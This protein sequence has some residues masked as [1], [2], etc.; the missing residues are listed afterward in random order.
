MYHQLFYEADREHIHVTVADVNVTYFFTSPLFL[1]FHLE[2][3]WS[4]K[5]SHV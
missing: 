2:V 3:V 4:L 1:I 5:L